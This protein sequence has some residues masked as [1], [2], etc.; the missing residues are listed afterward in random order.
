MRTSIPASVLAAVLL[1]GC[2][3]N[4]P[5]GLDPGYAG[6]VMQAQTA[7]AQAATADISGEW[8]WSDQNFIHLDE[9][10]AGLFG[11][12]PDGKRTT[13][14]CSHTG[15]L[16]VVQAG[17]TFT[18]S[19]DGHASC[20]GPNGAVVGGPSAS[21]MEG[22]IVGRSIQL[23][24]SDGPIQCPGHGAIR[25]EGGVAVGMK[26]TFGCIEPGHPRSGVQAP[27]PRAGPNRTQWE[28]TRLQ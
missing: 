20:V 14:R 27:A 16:T 25:S 8:A 28:A 17:S 10:S 11:F 23:A 1:I 22:S 19:F 24:L 18:A 6:D 15:I 26:G 4:G 21:F 9:F 5:A 13:I 2:D 7:A 12:A 3:A